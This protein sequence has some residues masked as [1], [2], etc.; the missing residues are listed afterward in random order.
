MASRCSVGRGRC[1]QSGFLPCF[2]L[3]IFTNVHRIDVEISRKRTGD[4]VPEIYIYFWDLR[5]GPEFMGWWFGESV[6]AAQVWG[7]CEVPSVPSATAWP[8]MEG[9]RIPWDGPVKGDPGQMAPGDLRGKLT[10]MNHEHV[11]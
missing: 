1:L 4:D 11:L 2:W 8:P 5:D 3:G 9:W 7:R 10:I 6:G